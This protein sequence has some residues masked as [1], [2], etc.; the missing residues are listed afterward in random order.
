[1]G[2]RRGYTLIEL[3]VVVLIFGILAAAAAPKY[4]EAMALYRAHVA[5]QRVAAD[6]RRV[7]EHARRTSTPQTLS[8]NTA[9]HTYSSPNVPD[10]DRPTLP[11]S[12]N[13]FGGDLGATLAA[14][15]FGG[16]PAVQFD[17]YGRPL[18]A[19]AVTVAI[20]QHTRLVTVDSTGLIAVP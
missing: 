18:T 11:M 15:N 1:M 12:V 13:L 9:N 5:A 2:R 6:I 8:F 7:R 17:I 14:A 3:V 19:G 16:S 20:G 4:V 10:I